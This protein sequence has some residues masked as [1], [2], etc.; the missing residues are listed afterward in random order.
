[1]TSAVISFTPKGDD[2]NALISKKL[3]ADSY[4]DSK[5]IGSFMNRMF[6]EYD[7]LIFIGAIGIAVRLV[8][9]YLKGKAVD[10][11][12]IVC[13]ENGEFVIP[14]LSGHIGGANDLAVKLSK[15]TNAVPVITTAT[16]INNIW[17]VDTW[18]TRNGYC[19]E[20]VEN[21]NYISST[22]LRGE[23]V[24][25]ACDFRMGGGLPDNVRFGSFENGIVISPF[26]KKPFKNTLN[27]VPKCVSVGV[28]SKKNAAPE[29]L[30]EAFKAAGLSRNAIKNI[31]SLDVKREEPCINMLRGYLNVPLDTYTADELNAVKGKFTKSDFVKNAVGVDNVCE[32]AACAGGGRLIVKKT[33]GEGVTFAAA[34]DD[35]EIRLKQN[36]EVIFYKRWVDVDGS[37]ISPYEQGMD[38][39]VKQQP[40]GGKN[41]ANNRNRTGKNRT[42]DSLSS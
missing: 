5:N 35:I 37:I 34:C 1:M 9:P 6:E 7:A 16:D 33:I 36:A 3:S 29:S 13:D 2:L 18:A 38:L 17:A 26:L 27:I 19:I 12:I 8:A 15:M 20:N 14:I 22:L 42:D 30:I 11:A 23:K 25:L 24:G 10:P 21:I 28:G 32:R 40:L 39:R 31:A 4:K 41:A